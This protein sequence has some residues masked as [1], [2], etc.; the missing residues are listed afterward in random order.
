[1]V[2]SATDGRYH[3][4]NFRRHDDWATKEVR[5]LVGAIITI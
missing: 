2:M 3:G 4:T 1:M 5:R